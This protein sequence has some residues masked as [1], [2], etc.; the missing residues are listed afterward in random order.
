MKLYF[1]PMEGITTYTYRNAHAEY[2]GGVDAYY[3]PFV[4]PS[5]NDKVNAKHFRDILPENNKAGELIPQIL[6]NSYSRFEHF[7]K[8]ID[9]LGYKKANINLGCPSGTVVKKGK[10]SGFLREPELLEMFLDEV[11]E[12]SQL[13]L[14]IKT[15]TGYFSGSEMENLMKIYNKYSYAKLIIHPRAREDKYNGVP[16][17]EVFKKAY[18]ISKNKVSYNGNVFSKQ[19]Y[20]EIIEEYPDLDS[21]MIGRGAIMNPAI[22]REIRGGA[23]LCKKELIEFTD[24]LRARYVELYKS[25]SFTLKKLKEIWTYV[26]WSFPDEKKIA[27]ELRKANELEEFM[28]AAKRMP[29]F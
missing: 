20:E 9:E 4:S 19:R 25:E 8:L 28:N 22:F 21:V 29:E 7:E 24:L 1:A 10:G 2:F 26:M 11:F 18:D 17:M 27:K 23:P 15:R 13:T 12:K 6:T 3:A 16:D 5:E 14:S